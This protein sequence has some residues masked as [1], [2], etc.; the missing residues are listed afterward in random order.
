MT[1]KY[2]NLNGGH[3]RQEYLEELEKA[4][5]DSYNHNSDGLKSWRNDTRQNQR[6]ERQEVARRVWENMQQK[7]KDP[8]PLD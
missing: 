1:T 8:D 4:Q 7:K 5:R 3:L 2:D 6:A